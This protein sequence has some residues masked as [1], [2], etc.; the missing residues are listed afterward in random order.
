M[1]RGLELMGYRLDW[2]NRGVAHQLRR[3]LIS[4]R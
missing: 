2:H 3:A 1:V 4:R